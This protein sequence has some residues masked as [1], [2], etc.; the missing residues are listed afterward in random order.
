[1][2]IGLGIKT[3]KEQKT[4]T[5]NIG[6]EGPAITQSLAVTGERRIIKL[7]TGG[8]EFPMIEM[9]EKFREL[10]HIDLVLS[11]LP[12]DMLKNLQMSATQEMNVHIKK[13]C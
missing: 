8:I 10:G 1:M 13:T 6:E 9:Q 12:M 11:Q 7:A 5:T 2:N 3:V 4:C